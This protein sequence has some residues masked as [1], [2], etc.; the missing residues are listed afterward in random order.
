MKIRMITLSAGPEGTMRPGEIHDVDEA[1]AQDM[2]SAG[3]AKAVNGDVEKRTVA[4]PEAAMVAAP[5][6]AA[7]KPAARPRRKRK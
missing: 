7:A 2:I 1:M 6:E 4:A 5:D 3:A